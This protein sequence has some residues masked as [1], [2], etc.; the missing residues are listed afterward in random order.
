MV[1]QDGQRLLDVAVVGFVEQAL[2]AGVGT[3]GLERQQDGQ[4][5][6]ALAEVGAG[7]LARLGLGAGHV[8]DVVGEL[9]AHAQVPAEAG[10]Q[11]HRL[12]R[13]G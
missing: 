9:E 12:G 6:H 2:Q 7:H 3:F 10:E 11:V 1:A 5:A 4:G 8:E 13:L